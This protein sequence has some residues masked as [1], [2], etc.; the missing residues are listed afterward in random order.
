MR[1]PRAALDPR[2]QRDQEERGDDERVPLLDPRRE[3]GGEDGDDEH[4]PERDGERRGEVAAQRR[5]ESR[6]IAGEDDRRRDRDDAD[7]EVELGPVAEQVVEHVAEVVAA[8][9]DD[10][11]RAEEVAA[12]DGRA[13]SGGATATA[14]APTRRR[15]QSRRTRSGERSMS[16]RSNGAVTIAGTS[17]IA[18]SRVAV[19]SP[20]AT[21][22][23]VAA[24]GRPLEHEDD[25]STAGRKIG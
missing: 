6:A 1:P 17:A 13:T 5:V 7:V 18:C 19:A 23:A 20:T 11:V 10:R 8:R 9:P 2:Q 24:P 21:S 16:A 14:P 3:L 12:P 25:S 22:A 4:E 15:G